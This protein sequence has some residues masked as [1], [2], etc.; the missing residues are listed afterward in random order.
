[1]ELDKDGILRLFY[2]ISVYFP[3]KITKHNNNILLLF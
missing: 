1:M 2:K 3:E